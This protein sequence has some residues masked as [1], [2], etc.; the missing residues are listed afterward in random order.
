[1]HLV[2]VYG[3]LKRGFPYHEIGLAGARFVGRCRTVE[4]YPLVVGGRWYSP[5]LIAEPGAGKRVFGE[6]YE[7]DDEKL[8][9]LDALEGTHHPAGYHRD[10]LA[11]EPV[12][13]GSRLDA[14][15]YFKHRSKVD[16]I[17]DDALEEYHLD[18]RYVM[19][20]DRTA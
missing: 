13:G 12:A 10:R 20:Q 4:A 8:A 19:A 15:S 9:Q 5:I 3:T 17:H 16:I 6:V 7:A 11:V 2:F 18:P 1:M 14:W